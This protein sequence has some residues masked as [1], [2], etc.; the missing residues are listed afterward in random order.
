MGIC[1]L[2]GDG[3][4]EVIATTEDN[5]LLIFNYKLNKLA[6]LKLAKGILHQ[7]FGAPFGA[8]K[9]VRYQKE[10]RLLVRQ[11]TNQKADFV[12][13]RL[14]PLPLTKKTN[15]FILALAI[16]LIILGFII[17]YAWHWLLH[18]SENVAKKFYAKITQIGYIVI[19]KKGKV[20]I[21][22]EHACNL[23]GLKNLTNSNLLEKLKQIG[24][25]ELYNKIISFQDFFNFPVTIKTGEQERFLSINFFELPRRN[26]YTL[27]IEDISK[28]AHLG[29]IEQ[30]APVAQKLAHSMK[31]P[32]M[33]IQLTTHQLELACA[34]A[35]PTKA[36]KLLSV[37]NEEVKRLRR[38]TDSF[39]RFTHFSPP[40]RKLEDINAILKDLVNKY[41]LSLPKEMKINL[42]LDEKLP[43]VRLDRAE[44]EFALSAIIENALEAMSEKGTL[45][46]SSAWRE[47]Y[48][49]NIKDWV[50]IT[51]AD[52]GKG[53][54][55]Q[56]LNQI[57]EPYFT[58]D[59][60]NGIGLGL[61]IA[62]QIV[63]RHYGTIKIQSKEGI[64]TCVSIN[65]PII[66]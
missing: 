54:P 43:Q 19:N 55:E 32:L 65:L 18:Y 46:I 1:D 66:E 62:E 42:T 61:S 11:A 41:Q 17:C 57:F 52:T 23:L 26:T 51:I 38:L 27:R 28:F 33:N 56:Y 63:K 12:L 59:K 31:T 13:Y 47:T 25:N 10:K 30:W 7:G 24:L 44:M 21:A 37:I 58:F 2:V 5:Q 34:E 53:I 40:D 4:K 35:D 9:L 48:E 49:G 8:V 20:T 50:E 22:N 6:Q 16:N 3:K 14:S 15:N 60:P 64:G 36:K 45:M 39:L 29:R